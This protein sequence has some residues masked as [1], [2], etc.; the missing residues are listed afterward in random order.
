MRDACVVGF[1][2]LVVAGAVSPFVCLGP[3]QVHQKHRESRTAADDLARL[4]DK[5]NAPIIGCNM[6]G[7]VTEWNEKACSAVRMRAPMRM[8]T[9]APMHACL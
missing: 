1:G 8:H 2:G 9:Q 7:E 6:A 3:P 4:I 5:A